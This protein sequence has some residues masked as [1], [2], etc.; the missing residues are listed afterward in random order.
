MGGLILNYQ[1]TLENQQ[2]DI[3]VVIP[4]QGITVV[5]GRSGS[6]KTSLINVIAGLSKP[7]KGKV[8]FDDAVLFDSEQAINVPV[9]R[10]DI[11]YVFQDARLF[12]H[13]KVQGNLC[14]GVTKRDENYFDEVVKL[15][16]LEHLLDCYPSQLSGG[17]KQRVAIGRALLSKPKMLLMDEPL[18][19]LDIPRKKEVMPFLEQL[20]QRIE[21]PII[22]VTHSL[23]ELLRLANHLVILER[24]RVKVAGEVAQVWSS[25]AMRPW[26]SFSDQSTLFEGKILEHSE[27]YAL[28]RIELAQATELWVQK[29]DLPLSSSVRLQIRAN[30]VSIALTKP[31]STSIRNILPAKITDLETFEFGKERQSISVKLELAQGCYLYATITAW[32][33]DELKLCRGMQVFAQIKGVSVTQKDVMLTH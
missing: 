27:G 21:I 31:E 29:V 25:N 30:D 20:S 15:L 24:G 23:N 7:T 3:D 9:Q 33:R 18:A 4:N 14:Y 19:S 28:S 12:P 1:Q 5:F 6:G 17:E 32:A 13:Y 26:L 22:Y 11:G 16:S 8:L 10:R 2:F